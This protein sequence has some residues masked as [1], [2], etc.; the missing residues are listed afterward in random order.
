MSATL[1]PYLNAVRATLQAAVCLENFSSQVVERHNKPEVEVRSSKELLL[2][3]VVISR[4]EKEKVLIEGSIN[5]VRVSIAVKQADEIERILCHKF[6]RFMMMRAENFFILRRKPVEG[7]DISFL[8]TNFH[9]EQ[10]YKHKLVDFVIHFMEEIDKEISE[11]KL[12]VNAR[13]RIVAEE[14]LKNNKKP[15]RPVVTMVT[16][17]K[18]QSYAD[19]GLK[20]IQTAKP[21]EKESTKGQVDAK[22]S[23]GAEREQESH[24]GRRHPEAILQNLLPHKMN[25]GP[26]AEKH[27][28][29]GHT[30]PT[31]EGRLRKNNNSQIINPDRLKNAKVWVDKAVKQKKIFSIHGPYPVIR[32]SL[33]NRGWVE[34][35]F[36]KVSRGVQKKK[37]ADDDNDND[38]DDDDDD[39]DGEEDD[40]RDD[41][42]GIYN[43]MSRLLKNEIVYFFWTTRRDAVDCRCLR[44]EQMTNHY[45]KAGSFTTK[46]GLCLNLRNLHWFDEADADT[47][48][49]RC[50]RLGAEDEKQ[51]FIEDFWLTAARSI[52]KLVVQKDKERHI[53]TNQDVFLQDRRQPEGKKAGKKKG[54]RVSSQLIE[55]ALCT[56]DEYLNSLEHEDIDTQ[57]KSP[58]NLSNS[59]WEKFLQSYYQVIHDG[60]IIERTEA[61][62]KQCERALDQLRLVTPQL[63]IEGVRNVWI[64]KP[65]AKSRG[66]GIIC[67]DRLDE[68]LKLVDC[69]PTVV[70]DGKWVVQK[71]IEKPLLIFGTK[72]DL[73]Q[74]FLVT[75]WNPLTIWFYRYSYIRFS[76]QPFSLDNL[77]TSIHLC[78]NSIQKHYVNSLRRNPHV[79]AD[80]MWSSEQFQEYLQQVGAKHVWSEVITPGMKAAVIHAMQTTQDVVEFRKNSFELY[81]ADFMFGEDFQPWLIEINASP[82]MAPSTAVT[83]KLCQNVQEDTIRVVI[84]RKFDRNCTTGAFELICKQPAVEIPQ[85]LGISLLVEG[86]TVKKP[87]TQ[88]PRNEATFASDIIYHTQKCSSLPRPSRS[89]RPNA[90]LRNGQQGTRKYNFN[91]TPNFFWPITGKVSDCWRNQGEPRSKII[92]GKEN[93][94]KAAW[95]DDNIVTYIERLRYPCN[96]EAKWEDETSLICNAAAFMREGLMQHKHRLASPKVCAVSHTEKILSPRNSIKLQELKQLKLNFNSFDR[97]AF[98]VEKQGRCTGRE[99]LV[100]LPM[101]YFSLTGLHLTGPPFSCSLICP[102]KKAGCSSRQTSYVQILREK[103]PQ[104]PTS[105]PSYSLSKN[106]PGMSEH[107]ALKKEG[108][109]NL[110]DP[111]L[112]V[113]A[114]PKIR[115]KRKHMK[116]DVDQHF[117]NR[118]RIRKCEQDFGIRVPTKT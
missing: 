38:S 22:D 7:Y 55:M 104:K 39:D 28:Q 98:Q 85:Y 46:V 36:P 52:L 25:P 58:F 48:F 16:K 37:T 17:V 54:D 97:V 11:M 72:F 77:D 34:K 65:G 99:Q 78:N 74:W 87:R 70:L 108:A 33:R 30:G 43:L 64:V 41:P 89:L 8:I 83:S 114:G 67:M 62:T 116:R 96:F 26:G 44:K 9:T 80:N 91:M 92:A 69:N 66:R 110:W 10:M 112:S 21:E 14:F 13:A 60:A 73:R 118:N 63:N 24:D 107:K 59:Q 106:E 51:A 82:T 61:Y 68:M 1:R 100:W 109:P 31:S 113:K 88:K 12:S 50:Y 49:P 75:D 95:K 20:P 15:R 105:T 5:S 35:M 3:P 94:A 90:D 47:F 32:N 42:D 57:N 40:E 117:K 93:R 23:R 115:N 29:E 76:T 79:P 86:S 102:Y 103:E 56:C 19:E 6:M 45:A 111:R 84:D 18:V 4:N 2:Q 101:K 53:S 27:K 71:Y 81:G